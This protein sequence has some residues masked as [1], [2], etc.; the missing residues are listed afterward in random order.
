MIENK[1]IKIG[2]IDGFLKAFC[3]KNHHIIIEFDFPHGYKRLSC[4]KCLKGYTLIP[5]GESFERKGN[6]YVF[7]PLKYGKI[8]T[9]NGN[10]GKQ[11]MWL[12][13]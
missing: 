11:N 13:G 12:I 4:Y 10:I 1:K 8:M 9:Q 2:K 7:M 3:P 5:N 6:R